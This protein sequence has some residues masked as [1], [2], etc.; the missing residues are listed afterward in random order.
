MVRA[1]ARTPTEGRLPSLGSGGRPQA[2]RF[3]RSA[4]ARTQ[5]GEA[6]VLVRQLALPSKKRVSAHL[7][8]AQARAPTN[9]RA[10]AGAVRAPAS[11]GGCVGCA[12]LF[13]CGP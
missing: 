12:Q 11:L 3:Q 13:C 7:K 4:P 10:G 1:V 8:R 9:G 6:R 2:G 5:A